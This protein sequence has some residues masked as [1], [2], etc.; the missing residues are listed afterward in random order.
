MQVNLVSEGDRTPF[1]NIL[2]TSPRREEDGGADG[3]E[4]GLQV[5][6]GHPLPCCGSGQTGAERPGYANPCHPF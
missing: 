3:L 1:V 2:T 5:G 4:G 6:A